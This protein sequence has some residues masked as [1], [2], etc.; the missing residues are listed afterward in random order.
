MRYTFIGRVLPER[1]YFGIS[2]P[3]QIENVHD[4]AG[5]SFTT[6][7]SIDVAQIS[8]EVL[9]NKGSTDIF[10]LK[11]IVEG[12]IRA[13]V[14]AFGYISGRGYDIEIISAIDENAK[15]TVFGVG[16]PALEASQKQR[17]LDFGSVLRNFANSQFLIPAL[18]DLRESI[19]SA[20]SGFYCYRAIECVRQHFY[21][22]QDGDDA[23][24]SWKR[25][26]EA[27]QIERS[28]IDV[29]GEYAKPQRHGKG[30]FIPDTERAKILQN[31][32]KVIDRFCI[33]LEKGSQPLDVQQFP[34]LRS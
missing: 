22:P 4:E 6:K 19:R 28:W 24:K 25:L 8:A 5:L 29:I 31:T 21:Q 33:Y 18:A 27:L 26:R 30:K 32:W 12:T 9:I 17:P 14:D 20:H 23:K 34:I 3:L 15:Q 11:N 16:V 10:T 2:Q 1:A 7:L 13:I